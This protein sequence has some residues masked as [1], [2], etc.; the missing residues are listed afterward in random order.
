MGSGDPPGLQNR[1]A[2]G[3]PVAGAFDS[4]TLPPIVESPHFDDVSCELCI[5]A[6]D[7]PVLFGVAARWAEPLCREV[8]V[9]RHHVTVAIGSHL[10]RAFDA[11]WTERLNVHGPG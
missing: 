3:L 6:R 11:F 9:Y 7:P 4:H 8:R 1:R 2:A 5:A 10:P